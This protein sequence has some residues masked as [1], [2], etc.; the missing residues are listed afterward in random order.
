MDGGRR[1]VLLPCQWVLLFERLT[2]ICWITTAARI[3]DHDLLAILVLTKM[4][5]VGYVQQQD[6]ACFFVD[7]ATVLPVLDFVGNNSR[8]FQIEGTNR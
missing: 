5:A 3:S 6:N 1:W 4:R 8:L 7:M 2:I